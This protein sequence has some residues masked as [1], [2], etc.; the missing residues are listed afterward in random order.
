MIKPHGSDI[1]ARCPACAESGHDQ[2]GEHLYLYADGR[3]GCVVYPAAE[4]MAHRQRIFKL[5]GMEEHQTKFRINRIQQFTRQP[6]IENI[7]GLLGRLNLT[8]A[9]SE[10][11]PQEIDKTI[12]QDESK[13][14]VPSVTT[15]FFSKEELALLKDID[16]ESL[17]NIADIKLLF[18]GRVVR[19]TKTLMI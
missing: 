1:I 17:Q 11:P 13:V 16:Q 6:I 3:F 18:N 4:G 15:D 8:L 14:S 10:I 19:A 2:K 5:A 12:S 9:Y 7:L